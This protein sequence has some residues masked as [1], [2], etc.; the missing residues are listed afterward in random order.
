MLAVEVVVVVVAVVDI[1]VAAG[2]EGDTIDG[3]VSLVLMLVEASPEGA[4]PLVLPAELVVGAEIEETCRAA[5]GVF[6]SYLCA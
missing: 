2:A 6:G 5:I 4:K 1:S 3:V